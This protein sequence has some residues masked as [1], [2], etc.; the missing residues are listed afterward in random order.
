MSEWNYD[1]TQVENHI[2]YTVSYH[3]GPGY[4]GV[5]KR[6]LCLDDGVWKYE[7]RDGGLVTLHGTVYAFMEDAYPD[8]APLPEG[9]GS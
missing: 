5:E 2:Y 8:P 7:H 3:H 9:F 4:Q 1:L 6:A